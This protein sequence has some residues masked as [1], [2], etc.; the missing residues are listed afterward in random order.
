MK[1]CKKKLVAFVSSFL[2][3]DLLILNNLFDRT[4]NVGLKFL[5]KYN[6]CHFVPELRTKKAKKYHVWGISQ[7]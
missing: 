6:L 7:H 4:L 1:L 2:Q 3:R 5:D